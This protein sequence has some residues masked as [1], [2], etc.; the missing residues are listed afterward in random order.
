V[1]TRSRPSIAARAWLAAALIIVTGCDNA[2]VLPEMPS[3][4]APPPIATVPSPEPVTPAPS[5]PPTAQPSADPIDGP[6]GGWW[7]IQET[8]RVAAPAELAAALDGQPFAVYRLVPGCAKDPCD[9]VGV[10]VLTATYAD[11][12]AEFALRLDA[13]VYTSDELAVTSG[14]CVAPDGTTVP[15]GARVSERVELW[16]EE[17]GRTGTAVT[18]LEL[19]GTRR[20]AARPVEAGELAGCG[21]WEATYDL[22]GSRTGAPASDNGTDEPPPDSSVTMVD[23]PDV[24][25]AIKGATV[26]YFSVKGRSVTTLGTSVANGG[27]R[28]CGRINY[29]WY[30]GDN[31]PAG[32][33]KT[34]WAAFDVRSVT[35]SDGSCRLDV[36]RIR[37]SFEVELPRWTAPSRV[38][39]AL[40]TWWTK[41]A[42][43]IRDHEAGHV[44]IGRRWVAKL[45]DQ[46]DGSTCSRMQRILTR[47][48][49]GLNEAQQAYDRR[50]YAKPWPRPP[51]GL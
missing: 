20:M 11:V 26:D 2:Q 10:T 46:L 40:A 21:P 14:P 43:F 4:T 30:D 12:L 5:A 38:P 44:T 41:T 15:G 8:P 29:E 45:R 3:A 16:L 24:R 22:S 7:R 27:L 13:H 37:A 19:R 32:C 51:A 36:R 9:R 34:G 6:V 35:R 18:S 23:R 49:T 42:R 1:G 25:L 39:K 33:T 31:R 28:A 47:W 17:V 50:E 48:A